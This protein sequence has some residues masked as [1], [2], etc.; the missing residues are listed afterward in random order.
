MAMPRATRLDTELRHFTAGQAGT[1]SLA[2]ELDQAAQRMGYEVGLSYSL[3][4]NSVRD[5]HI[6]NRPATAHVLAGNVQCS[7]QEPAASVLTPS[8]RIAQDA[9]AA[10]QLVSSSGTATPGEVE[11]PNSFLL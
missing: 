2:E 4:C 11:F 9:T 5:L 7:G 3:V 6:S 1:D 8:W 10:Q